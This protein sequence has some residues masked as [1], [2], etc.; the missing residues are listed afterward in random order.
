MN[1]SKIENQS[2]EFSANVEGPPLHLWHPELSGDI[3]II[4]KKNGDWFHEGTVFK[5]KSLVKLFASILRQEDDGEYY[6]VTPVEKWRIKVE[7]KPLIIVD[8]DFT[9][10]S[11]ENQKITIATNMEKELEISADHPLEVTTDSDTGAIEPVVR[12]DNGLSAKISRAAFYRIAEHAVD[13]GGDFS[14]LSN[15]V[16]FKIG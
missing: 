3:D 9:G 11:T 13:K 10:L 6:L 7:D 12:L 16:W 1:L 8:V 15:G 5:R 14:V 2:K 4:I